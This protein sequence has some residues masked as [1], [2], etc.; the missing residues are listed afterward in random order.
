[1]HDTS[2]EQVCR[3]QPTSIPQ[4]LSVH[5]IGERKAAMYGEQI[6]EALKAFRAGARA[7]EKVSAS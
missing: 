2:L 7:Q 3:L 1:M 6:F 5:G 4:L